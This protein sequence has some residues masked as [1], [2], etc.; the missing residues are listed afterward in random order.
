MAHLLKQVEGLAK[1]D[2]VS[3]CL[4]HLFPLLSTSR[5]FILW[6]LFGV[7]MGTGVPGLLARGVVAVLYFAHHR[8]GAWFQEQKECTAEMHHFVLFLPGTS[9]ADS[10]PL[11]L[12]VPFHP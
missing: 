1:G 5:A 9:A 12:P 6:V 3:F 11:L 8:W 10:V 4:T 2:G 7:L